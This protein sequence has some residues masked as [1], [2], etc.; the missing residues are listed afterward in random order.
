[1]RLHRFGRKIKLPSTAAI[2]H[3][4]RKLMFEELVKEAANSTESAASKASSAPGVATT[5]SR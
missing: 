2:K 1:M 4:I 5:A 3:Q